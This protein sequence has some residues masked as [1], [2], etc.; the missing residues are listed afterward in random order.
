MSVINRFASALNIRPGEGRLVN[1]L[2]LHSFFVG[3]NRVFLL[4]VSTSLFL[5]EFGANTLPFVYIATAVANSSV[6]FIYNWLGKRISFVRLLAANL[7]FQFVIVMGF[8]LLFG[9]TD[10]QWPAIALM[11]SIELLWLLTNLEFWTLS[12]RIFNIQQGKRLFGVVGAGDTLASIIGGFTV[13]FWVGLMGTRNLLLIVV[14]SIIASLV[15]IL[16]IARL[17]RS[18]L[19]I[20]NEPEAVAETAQRYA[21]PL[22]NRYLLLIFAFAFVAT[23]SYYFLDNAFYALTEIH[24]PDSDTLA[25]F[26]GVYFAV[27]ALVQ[28]GFQTFLAGRVINRLGIAVCIVL[29][30]L[31]GTIMMGATAVV[32]AAAGLAAITFGVMAAVRLIEYVL[33]GTITTSAQMTIY[34]SL[35]PAIRVQTQTQVESLVEPVTTGIAGILLLIILEALKWGIIHLIVLSI[36]V[37][38]VWTIAAVLLAREYPKALVQALSKRRLGNTQ[39]LLN[40]QSVANLVRSRLGQSDA[41]EALY[42]LNLLEEADPEALKKLLPEAVNHPVAQVRQDVLQRIEAMNVSAAVQAVRKL[43]TTETDA[44]VRAAAIGAAIV[45]DRDAVLKQASNY[46]ESDDPSMRVA[47]IAGLMRSEHRGGAALAEA[48]LQLLLDSDTPQERVLA[49]E[50]IGEVGRSDL[51]QPLLSLLHDADM[52]VRRS[53]VAAA[54]RFTNADLW[55]AVIENLSVKGVRSAAVSALSG[56]D[57]SV[58]PL[59]VGTLADIRREAENGAYH[60]STLAQQI[61]RICGRLR[62]TS[63]LET[64]IDFPNPSVRETILNALLQAKYQATNTEQIEAQIHREIQNDLWYLQGLTLLKDDP[65]LPGALRYILERMRTR[66]FILCSFIYDTQ[67][68]A[69]V[70]SDYASGLEGQRSYAVEV[71]HVTLSRDLRLLVIALLDDAIESRQ[72]LDALMDI[73]EQPWLT[74]EAWLERILTTKESSPWLRVSALYGI[75]RRMERNLIRSVQSITS[76]ESHFVRET[77]EWVLDRLDDRTLRRRKVLLSIEKMLLLKS[78]SLFSHV[79]DPILFEIA[80]IVKDET[81]LEG[82]TIIQKDELGDCMYIIA[83]GRVR[84]HDGEQTIAWMG[85]K[86]VFGELAL[87]DAEPRNATVTA[88]EETYLLRLDQSTFY[89]LISDYPEVLRGIIRVLSLRL[90]ETTRRSTMSPSSTQEVASA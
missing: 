15:V 52:D 1:L 5:T 18:R 45:I 33:R 77:A 80:S 32:G 84:I 51:Y 37:G 27:M 31:L 86:E 61:A 53:A 69:R 9:L 78:V 46:L 83:S 40:E 88:V 24:Y 39:Y 12:A 60:R 87:L 38:A 48:Q 17:Y 74:R 82:K 65:L 44:N 26:L 73:F 29:V 21:N 8:W 58:L 49:G 2:F 30:P 14:A 55:S 70:R 54:G 47:T 71:L 41:G 7:L 43:L 57:E 22:K 85:E 3:V 20:E 75:R 6:G 56:A 50:V 34:Q 79:P 63:V 66:I 59:F 13:P 42:L 81:A 23:I 35:P 76:D 62:N 72:G 36:L 90:R 10:A 28:L 4:S 68:M 19:S 11:I 64:Y 25:G 89:E 16:V 67:T